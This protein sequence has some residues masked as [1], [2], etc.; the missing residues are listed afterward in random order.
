[1]HRPLRLG[2]LLAVI[3]AIF[4]CLAQP[5][6]AAGPNLIRNGTFARP[7]VN[8]NSYQ[9]IGAGNAFL[10]EDW[11]LTRGDVDVFGRNLAAA[12]SRHQALNLN[13]TV[14]GTV[15]QDFETRPGTRITITW[16]HARDTW[17]GCAWANDQ[18][19]DVS[20]HNT[21]YGSYEPQGGPGNWSTPNSLSFVAQGYSYTLEFSSTTGLAT[22]ACGALI[23]DVEVRADGGT[24]PPPPNPPE[25]RLR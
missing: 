14:P 7:P 11:T 24:N 6:T 10:L 8:E 13:G 21:V 9:L 22:P 1:M 5:A 12:P 18:S 23:T 2:G 15:Q 17:P 25:P 16:K 19:Y 3:M 4:V 20:V